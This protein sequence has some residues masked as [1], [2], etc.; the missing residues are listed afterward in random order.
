MAASVAAEVGG[1]P[2]RDLF[3]ETELDMVDPGTNWPLQHDPVYGVCM[4][5]RCTV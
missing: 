2:A 5:T 1:V 3:D 4:R